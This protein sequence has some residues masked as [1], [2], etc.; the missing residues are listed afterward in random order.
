[1]D[2]VTGTGPR[3]SVGTHY[4]VWWFWLPVV[5]GCL[6]LVSAGILLPIFPRVGLAAAAAALIC[7]IVAGTAAFMI[8]RGRRWIEL[9]DDGFRVSDHSVQA[10]IHDDQITDLAIYR[11]HHHGAGKLLAESRHLI[12]WLQT[13]AGRQRLK[14][15]SRLAPGSDD[16]LQPLIDRLCERLLE[17]AKRRRARRETIDGDGWS[18]APTQ[19]QVTTKRQRTTLPLDEI[20]AVETIGQ[21]IRI[22]QRDNPYTVARLPL[23]GRN[24]WLLDRMIRDQLTPA[25]HPRLALN[26][27]E[28]ASAGRHD[29]MTPSALGRILF[30]REAGSG[31]TIIFGVMGILMAVVGAL[32]LWIAVPAADPFLSAAGGL[33]I[34]L[35]GLCFVGGWRVQR[36]RFRCC[37]RGLERVTMTS[38][39][40]LPFDDIDVFSFECRR[41]QSQGRYTGTTYTLVF[42]DR[43]REQGR[44]IF[45][46]TTVRNQDEELDDLRDRI[47]QILARRMAQTF[48]AHQSVQWTPEI[49]FRRDVIEFTRRRRLFR[50]TKVVVVPYDTITDFEL[51]DGLFHI[52]TSYQERAVLSIPTGAPNFY[53]GMILFEG[54]VRSWKQEPVAEAV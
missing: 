35:S 34:L 1:M 5:F 46:S 52:W 36:I 50:P 4:R 31:A 14:F 20:S 41:N 9:S 47:S 30:E 21:E 10:I 40:V 15:S 7:L 3:I 24:G 44:G 51:R 12:T 16:P 22:W 42:A 43:S 38:R 19:L 39:K 17:S 54:L 6:A 28:S 45:Y 2:F 32:S 53:P 18:L 29:E 33:L 26:D 25:T 37:E 11:Q 23:F 13:E 48:A 49:W 27:T 8:E